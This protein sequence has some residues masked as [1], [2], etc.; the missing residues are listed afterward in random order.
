[1]D[2]IVCHCPTDGLDKFEEISYLLKNKDT[3]KLE[4]FLNTEDRPTHAFPNG[5]R[6]EITE[7]FIA[8]VKKYFEVSYII[9]NIL[10]PSG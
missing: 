10:G 8:Q 4:E 5:D 9:T 2:F 6:K 7:K 1:M 3:V